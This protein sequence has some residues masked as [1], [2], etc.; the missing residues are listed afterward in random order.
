MNLSGD[1]CASLA[2]QLNPLPPCLCFRP[3]SILLSCGIPYD[4][5]QNALRLSVGRDTTRA[6][7]DV[8]VQD[9]VQAVAQLGEDQAS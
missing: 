7:V 8:V 4:V 1:V 5:A 9:L 6:D 2:S 3:S